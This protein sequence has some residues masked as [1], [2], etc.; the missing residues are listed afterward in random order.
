MILRPEI[1]GVLAFLLLLLA[2]LPVMLVSGKHQKKID[3]RRNRIVARVSAA[4]MDHAGSGKSGLRKKEQKGASLVRILP[5]L[6]VLRGRLERS[7]TGISL[8]VYAMGCVGIGLVGL[9]LAFFLAK[10]SLPVSVLAG[11]AMGAGLPHFLVSRAIRKRQQA[12]VAD[13]AEAIDL[14]VRGLR[15]GLPVS[16]TIA[17]VGREIRPPVGQEFAQIAEA[18]RLGATLSEALWQA[19]KR[20]DLPEFN[21]FVVSLTVQ[22]ETGGNLSETLNNLAEI[23]RRRAQTKLK[24]N[25]L[26]SEARASAMIIG[27]LPFVMMAIL[28]FVNPAYIMTLFTDPSGNMMLLV[29]GSAMLTGFF[30]I[31]RMIKFDM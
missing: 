13:F 31:N 26:S 12:F 29:G 18:V 21:F 7:A 5:S 10:L 14:M 2:F 16:E 19:Q 20:L 9:I 6:D 22:Q 25:A 24:I 15:S 30:V 8:P 3:A 1:L 28:T 23:L 17:A 4:R 27:A 11:I